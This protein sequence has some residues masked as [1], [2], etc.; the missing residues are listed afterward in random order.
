MKRTWTSLA[1]AVT[2]GLLCAY[3]VANAQDRA[4]LYP[5]PQV[6]PKDATPTVKPKATLPAV[7]PPEPRIG[8]AELEPTPGVVQAGGVVALPQFPAAPA[9][10]KPKESK[11]P[12]TESPLTLP[13]LENQPLPI[14]EPTK[15]LIV[16]LPSKEISKPL[17]PAPNINVAPPSVALPAPMTAPQPS[18]TMP[19]TKPK[20]FVRIRTGASV[21]PPLSLPTEPPPPVSAPNVAIPNTGASASLQTPSVSVEKR[22]S[23]RLRAGE[24]QAYQIVLRNL[25]PTQAQQVRIE[26]EIPPGSKI[27]SADPL[28]SQQ[29]NKAIWFVSNLA[30]NGEQVIRLVLQSASDVEL[31][32]RVNVQVAAST[33]ANPITA[34]R[35]ALDVPAI[36]VKLAPPAVTA[37]GRAAVFEIR[38]A[39]QSD[40]PLTGILLTGSLPEG[41]NTAQ[42]RSIEGEV[43][44]TIQPG[45]V[46]TLRMPTNAVKAGRYTVAVKVSAR[47]GLEA[48]ASVDIDITGATLNVLQAP[49]TRLVP[50]RAGDLRIEVT[51][52]TGKPL[53]NVTV[54]DRIPEGLEFVAASE[55]G[56]YQANSRSVYWQFTELPAGTSKALIVRVHGQKPGEHENVVQ[57]R[58]DGAADQHSVGILQV[59]GLS[60]LSLR[61]TARDPLVEVGN[62]AVYEIQVVNPGSAPATNVQV[63]LLFP[64]G[65][66]PKNAQSDTRFSID[67]QALIFEPI[68]S[69]APQGQ[70]TFRVSAVAQPTAERDQ[71][72]RF[73][74][75]SDQA[76]V[77]IQKEIGTM[78]VPR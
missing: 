15:A 48:S 53:R 72:V 52:H 30:V 45:E 61:V 19:D 24:S 55:R 13:L 42:G 56:L 68:A 64:P 16:D 28:P 27:V 77:A 46:K 2:A 59:E 32:S 26:D 70:A 7:T 25:G 44:A 51:N 31:A 35:P 3:W 58:A 50:G 36:D 75:V 49:T 5:P 62:E 39:N 18:V 54:V 1:I 11:G 20:A 8:T 23:P 34:Q 47:G 67:R 38:I 74:L 73:S 41:L 71:R 66:A 22:G 43:E 10:V 6:L 65:L 37:V 29:G 12:S 21:P 63:K 76:P 69:L 60:D 78:V 17:I 57:L 4:P 9:I 40:R 14:P 33:Q